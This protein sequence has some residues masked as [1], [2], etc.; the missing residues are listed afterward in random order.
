MST[1]PATAE[2]ALPANTPY[3]YLDTETLSRLN[4]PRTKWCAGTP[5]SAGQDRPTFGVRRGGADALSGRSRMAGAPA[6]RSR[7]GR[8]W[9]SGPVRSGVLAQARTRCGIAC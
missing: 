1:W 9:F 5:L 8:D 4:K 2:D 7:A 3:Q 6:R